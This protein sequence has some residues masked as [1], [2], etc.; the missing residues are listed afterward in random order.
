MILSCTNKR[1]ALI[2]VSVK[3]VI[4]RSDREDA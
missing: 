2:R 3:R 1:L 4:S